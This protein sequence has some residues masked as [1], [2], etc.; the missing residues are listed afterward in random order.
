MAKVEP[1]KEENDE[2]IAELK[3][4][5]RDGEIIDVHFRNARV[6]VFPVSGSAYRVVADAQWI[7][8]G[9]VQRKSIPVGDFYFNEHFGRQTARIIAE[10]VADSINQ[11]AIA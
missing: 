3:R 8:N 10:R 5:I 11:A 2:G 1:T 9:H 4:Q 7:E 6:G